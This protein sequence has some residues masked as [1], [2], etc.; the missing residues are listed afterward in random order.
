MT[1]WKPVSAKVRQRVQNVLNQNLVIRSFL[2]N[3]FEA[4][5]SSETNVLSVSKYLFSVFCTFLREEVETISWRSEA[6]RSKLFKSKFG[7]RN[8]LKKWF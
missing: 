2:E 7:H 1:E 8:L 4:A 3:G 5:L 6:K